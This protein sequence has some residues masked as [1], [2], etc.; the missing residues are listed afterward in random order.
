M[1]AQAPSAVTRVTRP[2]LGCNSCDAAQSPLRGVELLQRLRKGQLAGGVGQDL[3]VAE[4][5]Y[6]LAASS[7]H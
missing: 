1:V 3:P 4:P 2:M 5:C 6:A 7:P